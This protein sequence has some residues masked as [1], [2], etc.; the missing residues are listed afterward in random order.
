MSLCTISSS[1]SSS[2]SSKVH[3]LLVLEPRFEY[4]GRA[5]G[6]DSAEA[7]LDEGV[8]AERFPLLVVELGV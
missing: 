7:A 4:A 2:S 3:S 6:E 1:S 8:L 5:D